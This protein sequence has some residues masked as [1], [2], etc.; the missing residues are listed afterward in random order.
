M[1]IFKYSI[2]LILLIVAILFICDF[3]PHIE[4]VPNKEDPSIFTTVGL[5]HAT[6]LIRTDETDGQMTVTFMDKSRTKF[7]TNEFPLYS[8]FKHDRK[9]LKNDPNTIIHFTGKIFS[10][11][12]NP[13]YQ[14]LEILEVRKDK[15]IA[16]YLK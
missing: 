1:S 10:V 13:T 15:Y 14:I 11:N 4:F 6:A 5:P 3:S 7:V 12:N 9:I 8:K 2:L 16:A